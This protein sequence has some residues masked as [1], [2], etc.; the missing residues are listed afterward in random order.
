MEMSSPDGPNRL[1]LKELTL[2]I[3]VFLETHQLD[4]NARPW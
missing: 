1:S 3:R 2:A 4:R